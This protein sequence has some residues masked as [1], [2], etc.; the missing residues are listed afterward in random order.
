MKYYHRKMIH[1][2]A[3]AFATLFIYYAILFTNLIFTSNI[4]SIY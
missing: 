2:L 4:Y 3:V 1:E